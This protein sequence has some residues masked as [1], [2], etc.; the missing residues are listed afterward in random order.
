MPADVGFV[1]DDR[2]RGLAEEFQRLGEIVGGT[3]AGE[4]A[5]DDMGAIA[6]PDA[7]DVL[8]RPGN[9]RQEFKLPGV[10]GRRAGGGGGLLQDPVQGVDGAIAHVDDVG[11]L[12]GR[13]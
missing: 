5:F 8:A 9:R 7:K 13:G 10:E 4:I 3:P 12:D 6:A 11:H 2:G 1:A